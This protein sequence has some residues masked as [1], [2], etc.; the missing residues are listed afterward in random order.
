VKKIIVGMD[1]SPEAELAGGHAIDLARRDGAE[2]VL[3]LAQASPSL[4]DGSFANAPEW[5][6][7]YT[8]RQ[9]D[10]ARR[11]R[12]RLA[13]LH[14]RWSGQGAPIT[15]LVVDGFAD[16]QVPRIA[17][18]LSA[19]L[20]VVGTQGRTG[21]ARAFLGSVAE[22]VVRLSDRPVLV[23]RGP[24]PH[25]GYHRIVVGSD[26]TPLAELA[27]NR[28]IELAARDARIDVLH[29]WQPSP[30]V[31]TDPPLVVDE[32]MRDAFLAQLTATGAAAAERARRGADLDIR[33]QLC[34]RLPAQGLA[35]YA[36]EVGADLIAVGS[37]GRR[38]FRRFLLGSVAEVTVR[39]AP[40]AVLIAR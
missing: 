19:D 5:A 26:F 6:E 18:E 34:E 14:Q 22:R 11:D 37:H 28:A 9:R 21:L 36:R 17:A 33:F 29:C 35:E 23:A 27:L 2:V 8:E 4:P 24:A 31:P 16:E 38:G 40:C 1:L 10:T 15:K 30:W 20:I 12:D 39:N 25:G 32:Q 13:E 3:V 7:V